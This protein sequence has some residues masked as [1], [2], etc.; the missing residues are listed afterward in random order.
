MVQSMKKPKSL[1]RC[2]C[3]KNRRVMTSGDG[4]EVAFNGTIRLLVAQPIL[5]HRLELELDNQTIWNASCCS[6]IC[7]Y[8]NCKAPSGGL[9]LPDGCALAYPTGTKQ[10]MLPH[11]KSALESSRALCSVTPGLSHGLRRQFP[12]QRSTRCPETLLKKFRRSAALLVD[13]RPTT[14]ASEAGE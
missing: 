5:R 6:T 2:L 10:K 13:D 3:R 11:S 12:E 9:E 14:L 1:S 7:R 8:R 4:E